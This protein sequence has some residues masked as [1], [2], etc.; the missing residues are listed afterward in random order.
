[1]LAFQL[2]CSIIVDWIHFCFHLDKPVFYYFVI[3]ATNNHANPVELVTTMSIENNIL[4]PGTVFRMTVR[5]NSPNTVNFRA[6][7]R[8]NRFPVL[9]NGRSSVDLVPSE[10]EDSSAQELIIGSKFVKLFICCSICCVVALRG[11][12]RE[13]IR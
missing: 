8:T 2:I 3:K 10:S 5:S 6:Y 4:Q 13:N 7:D 12:D 1:M 9:I 11:T